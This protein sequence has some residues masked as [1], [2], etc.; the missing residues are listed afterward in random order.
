MFSISL[1]SISASLL[2]AFSSLPLLAPE[3][4]RNPEGISTLLIYTPSTIINGWLLPKIEEIP[5]NR[6]A[7][8][9]PGAPD[10]EMILTPVNLPYKAPSTE[11]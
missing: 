7:K 10:E 11:V 5:R 1:G 3:A 6:S 8:P 9:P 2:A 4:N